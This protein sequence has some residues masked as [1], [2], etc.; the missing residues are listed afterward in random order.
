MV[1]VGDFAIVKHMVEVLVSVPMC[2]KAV[3]CL[4]QKISV[5]QKVHSYLSYSV[6]GHEFH[7][8]KATIY[9]T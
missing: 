1:F 6:S 5:L 9:I 8:N 4:I 2:K 3:M 7:V